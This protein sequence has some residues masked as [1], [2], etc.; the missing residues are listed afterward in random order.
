MPVNDRA[1]TEPTRLRTHT[2]EYVPFRSRR[3]LVRHST[4]SKTHIGPDSRWQPR[5]CAVKGLQAQ[6][7]SD[8]WTPRTRCSSQGKRNNK[9][10]QGT[11]GVLSF[12]KLLSLC[13]WPFFDKLFCKCQRIGSS[14]RSLWLFKTI[15]LSQHRG[16]WNKVSLLTNCFLHQKQYRVKIL[17]PAK[18]GSLW[19][20]MLYCARLAV[21]TF[22]DLFP[23]NICLP[24]LYFFSGI[25][26]N[27]PWASGGSSILA[28]YGTLHLEFMHLS[29]LS[30]N[31]DFAQKV[32]GPAI[33][34]MFF[35][36]Y[37]QPYLFSLS[38]R[39]NQVMNIR[40]V[41]NRL[42]KPQG[43]YPNYLNPNSGQWGQRKSFPA[44]SNH[45][46]FCRPSTLGSN[47]SRSVS[48]QPCGLLCHRTHRLPLNTILI[49]KYTIVAAATCW[50]TST[51]ITVVQ[52]YSCSHG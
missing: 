38:A 41:L 25:G 10:T 36:W 22:I 52:Y 50:I 46:W 51:H 33:N 14:Y 45:S 11:D 7:V 16:S 23:F 24:F 28:E 15:S 43:L 19:R 39:P 49:W 26:R 37:P 42:D 8:R 44:P 32:N 47:N 20:K 35:H 18:L 4:A 2:R 48:V 21:S 31:P 6:R 9:K 34:T 3:V 27:W 1:V 13:N 30:G 5:Q 12:I 29:K 17:K 40:K